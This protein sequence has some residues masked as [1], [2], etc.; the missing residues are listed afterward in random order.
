MGRQA[1][2]QAGGQRERELGGRYLFFRHRFS[3][4]HISF[5]GSEFGIWDR[6]ESH[7]FGSPQQGRD[8]RSTGLGCLRFLDWDGIFDCVLICP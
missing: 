1:G 4:G 6:S 8:S 7:G 5:L 2:R 3:S